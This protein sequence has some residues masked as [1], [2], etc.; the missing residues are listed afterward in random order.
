MA[1]T[2]RVLATLITHL[3]A[4]C[5]SYDPPLPNLLG[6]ELLNEPQQDASLQGWY[7]DAIQAVRSINPSIPIYIGDSWMTDHYAGFIESNSSSM[8][9]TVLDH[10]LYRCFT[11]EDTST[12]VT[13]HTRDLTDPNAATPQMLSRVSQKLEGAGGA[14]II[15]EWSGGLNPGSLRNIG[16][17]DSARREFV[18]AQLGLY[19]RV[20]AGNFFWTYKK[21]H[22]GDK[23]W[24]LR[25]AFGAGVFPPRV[26]LALRDKVLRDDP[27]RHSRR[28]RACDKALG[29]GYAI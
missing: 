26:G 11:H 4:F 23:G 3:T 25:D 13:Q 27:G 9:F 8:P 19:E 1:H 24:S 6:V 10:H 22:P 28:D 16:N 5:N 17:E 21:E 7:K 15:G 2:I 29:E 12:S 14:L 20:C 18:E